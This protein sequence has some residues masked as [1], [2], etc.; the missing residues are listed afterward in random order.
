MCKVNPEY[1][2]KLRVENGVKVMNLSIPKALYRCMES[3]LLW[4]DPY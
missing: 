3:A 4:Y 1:K 2:K